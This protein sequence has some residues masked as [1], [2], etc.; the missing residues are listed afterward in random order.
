MKILVAD[1]VLYQFPLLLLSEAHLW[2]IL[3]TIVSNN[4]HLWLIFL[5][6]ASKHVF[7]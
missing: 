7:Q 3:L 4:V 2:L 6:I 1:L 5:T